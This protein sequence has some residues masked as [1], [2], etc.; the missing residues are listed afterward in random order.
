MT[1][2]LRY[3][4]VPPERPFSGSI[5]KLKLSAVTESREPPGRDHARL[6]KDGR[7]GQSGAC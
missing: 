7:D 2:D 6:C 1:N 5:S 4:G 3:A